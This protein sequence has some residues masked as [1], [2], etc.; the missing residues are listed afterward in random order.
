MENSEKHKI[1]SFKTYIIVLLGLITFTAISVYVTHIDL[2][3]FSIAVALILAGLKSLLVFAVF[4]HLFYD[5][6]MYAFMVLGVLVVM[7]LVLI[8]TFFDYGF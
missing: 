1:V 6:R 4:M 5:K 8:I 3:N 7:T 2:G